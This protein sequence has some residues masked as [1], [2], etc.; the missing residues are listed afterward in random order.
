MRFSSTLP[1][2]MSKFFLKAPS[3][4]M[5]VVPIEFDY[6]WMNNN[7]GRM[8]LNNVHSPLRPNPHP[9]CISVSSWEIF[10]IILSIPAI[11]G[12]VQFEEGEQ[13]GYICILVRYTYKLEVVVKLAFT[14]LIRNCRSQPYLGWHKCYRRK[15]DNTIY[16]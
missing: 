5:A 15:L 7:S 8:I 10:C 6:S 1:T 2:L 9:V 14:I 3:L 4:P 16:F 11:A 13:I 12:C